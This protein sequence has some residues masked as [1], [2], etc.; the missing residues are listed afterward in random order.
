MKRRTLARQNGQGLSGPQ[1]R[2]DLPSVRRV[3]RR[4]FRR[5]GRR[6]CRGPL[7]VHP[8]TRM[9][10]VAVRGS[11]GDASRICRGFLRV[12]G[13]SIPPAPRAGPCLARPSVVRAG[14]Q[15]G[16]SVRRCAGR[17]GQDAPVPNRD[18]LICAD[19]RHSSG[20]KGRTAIGR[21]RPIELGRDPTASERALGK[22]R[23]P[24]LQTFGPG[25]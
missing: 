21:P 22:V 3:E 19:N 11:V 2:L 10:G 15:C 5:A 18:S 6:C 24:L 17:P 8:L 20:L 4:R 23:T 16:P 25:H 13:A 12:H 1:A 7:F 9:V 14:E